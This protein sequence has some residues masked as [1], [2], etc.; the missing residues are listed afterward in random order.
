MPNFTIEFKAMGSHMQVWLS[1]PAIEDAQILQNIPAWFE[2][3]ESLFSR[4][5]PTSELCRLNRHSGQWWPVSLTLFEVISAAVQGAEETRGIFNP[6]I[7]PALRAAGYDH[8]FEPGTFI[9]AT[10]DIFVVVPDFHQIEL[11]RDEPLVRLPAGAELDLGGIVKGWAAQQTAKRL[12]TVGPCLVDAGGDMVAIGAPDESGGWLV[13]VANP[14]TPTVSQT[15]RLTDAAIATSGRDYRRWERDGHLLHH[16]I[17]PYTGRPATSDVLSASV[18]APSAVQA[19]VWAKASIIT[20][21][22][23]PFPTLLV[24]DDGSISCNKEFERL[25][26]AEKH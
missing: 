25:C 10:Q 24:S 19:E 17:D 14:V 11:K 13:S 22:V 8:S 23:A 21:T 2:Y 4:F 18:I 12:S 20:A 3:W 5:R 26:I 15:V 7:L 16:I 1:V 6:L 9:P